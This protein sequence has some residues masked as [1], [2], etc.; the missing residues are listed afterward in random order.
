ML[1]VL[2]NIF[3]FAK[4]NG[5]CINIKSLC[6]MYKLQRSFRMTLCLKKSLLFLFSTSFNPWCILKM[7]VLRL[8]KWCQQT[9]KE[10]IEPSECRVKVYAWESMLESS[11][12][13]LRE[14]GRFS[15]PWDKESHMARKLSGGGGGGVCLW[16][17]PGGGPLTSLCLVSTVFVWQLSGANW[18]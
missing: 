7:F 15:T 9:A 11:V 10:Q 3:P 6:F 17:G 14:A 1:V 4:K 13:E 2:N 12:F 18:T 16:P 5:L 8:D